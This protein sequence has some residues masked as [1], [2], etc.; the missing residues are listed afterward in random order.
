MGLIRSITVVHTHVH[1]N[2]L[3]EYTTIE[4]IVVWLPHVR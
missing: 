1:I 2:L 4:V 3:A